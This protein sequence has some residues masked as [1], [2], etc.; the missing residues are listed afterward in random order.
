M[1]S[2]KII[3]KCTKLAMASF[4]LPNSSKKHFSF[5][6]ERNKIVSFGWNDGWKSHPLAAKYGHR[7]SG[8]HSELA[9]IRNF[10]Y[11]PGYI[12]N[13]TLLN[14]RIRNDKTCGMSRPC[15]ACFNLLAHFGLYNIFYSNE[16]GLVVQL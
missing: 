11:P 14:I 13:F 6:I 1:L 8:I 9:A 3:N 7:F 4:D 15:L 16:K 10:P 5:I 12:K 2:Q